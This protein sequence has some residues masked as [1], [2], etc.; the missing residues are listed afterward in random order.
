MFKRKVGDRRMKKKRLLELL[1]P[2]NDDFEI[3]FWERVIT[4][5]EIYGGPSFEEYK[6]VDEQPE[7]GYSS[8]VIQFDIRKV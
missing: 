7:I 4:E 2:Y 1:E 8:K 3:S 6:I 5:S